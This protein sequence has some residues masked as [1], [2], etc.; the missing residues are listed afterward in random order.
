MESKKR[1]IVK[2]LMWRIIATLI[3]ITTTFLFIQNFDLALFVGGFDTIL[4]L[5]GYYYHERLWIKIKFGK[6]S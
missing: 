1:T 6:E 3:T 2:T 5:I 4:K